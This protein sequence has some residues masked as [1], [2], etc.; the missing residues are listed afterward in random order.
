MSIMHHSTTTV[1]MYVLVR[2]GGS[3]S[4]RSLD[5]SL[6]AVVESSGNVLQVGHSTGTGSSSSLSL[7]GPVVRSHLGVRVAARSTLSLSGVQSTTSTSLAQDV[8]LVVSLTH[9]WSTLCFVSIERRAHNTNHEPIIHK[10]IIIDSLMQ[11]IMDS[12]SHGFD[13]FVWR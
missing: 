1:S 8:R 12:H 3:L 9:R 2:L 11:S 4:G 13:R 6:E 5:G 10:S 7:L